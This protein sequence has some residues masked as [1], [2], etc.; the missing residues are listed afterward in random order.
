MNKTFRAPTML[1]ALR[2]VQRELGPDAMVVSVRQVPGGPTWQV[3]RRPIYE[4]IATTK[5]AARSSAAADAKPAAAPAPRPAPPAEGKPTQ[6]LPGRLYRTEAQPKAAQPAAEPAVSSKSNAKV[7][8]FTPVRL[9]SASAEKAAAPAAEGD[10]LQALRHSLQGAGS[11]QEKPQ[12][13]AAEVWVDE[14][15]SN[16]VSPIIMEDLPP[17]A[18]MDD[19]QVVAAV[20]RQLTEQGVDRLLVN[21]LLD[22]CQHVLSPQILS[23]EVRLRRYLYGQLEVG[24]HLPYTPLLENPPHLICLVGNTGCGKTSVCAKL[25]AHYS[26]VLGKKVAW[27]NADTV[28]TGAIGEAQIFTE[29]LGI[30]LHQ[31]YTPA[32]LVEAVRAAAD[33]EVI[34]VDTPGCNPRSQLKVVEIGSFLTSLKNRTT[35]LVASAASKDTDL[36]QLQAALGPFNIQGLIITKLDETCTYGSIYNFA[37][38]SQLPLMCFTTGGR[39]MDDL[40]PAAP[41]ELVYAVFGEGLAQ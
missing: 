7:Q 30:P 1:E 11:R 39:V 40:H 31:V 34:L 24:L 20:R 37:W 41:A 18:V 14:E 2:Q 16:L 15:S 13:P 12:P 5:T 10:L 36:N 9:V 3:W 26:Q 23:D 19:L 32:E 28:R 27:I 21:R 29:T 6:S 4:V 8:P 17:A 38:R 35:Y 25:A 22:N 33:A